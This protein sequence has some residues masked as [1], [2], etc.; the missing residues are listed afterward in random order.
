MKTL[1]ISIG[2]CIQGSRSV[3]IM[4]S[5]GEAITTIIRS[6][7][8]IILAIIRFLLTIMKPNYENSLVNMRKIS[9]F[10]STNTGTG[11]KLWSS[12]IRKSSQL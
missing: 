8:A 5:L 9:Q 11:G 4:A 2:S 10:Q 7:A 3:A 6:R 12:I 1:I